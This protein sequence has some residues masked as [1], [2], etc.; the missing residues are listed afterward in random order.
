MSINDKYSETTRTDFDANFNTEYPGNQMVGYTLNGS[1]IGNTFSDASGNFTRSDYINNFWYDS[2]PLN[3][4]FASSIKLPFV[5]SSIPPSSY[6]NYM[7]YTHVDILM[8]TTLT[9]IFEIISSNNITNVT[10]ISV[11]CVGGGGHGAFDGG[12]WG[13]GGGGAGT[14][15][16]GTMSVD[17][18]IQYTIQTGKSD[19]YSRITYSDTAV[20][21][22]A[23]SGGRGM[24]QFG[25]GRSG[26]SGG[27]GSGGGDTN[28]L[29]ASPGENYPNFTAYKS[30]G[31]YGVNFK[32]GGGGGGALVNGGNAGGWEG[33]PGGAGVQWTV[34]GATYGG[35]GA[36]QGVWDY[37]NRSSGGNG[38]GGNGGQRGTDG[39]GGGGGAGQG[40]PGQRGG[41]GIVIIAVPKTSVSIPTPYQL[42]VYTTASSYST[43]TSIS[44][45]VYT[46]T[47]STEFTWDYVKSYA[48]VLVVGGGG[49]GGAS[50]GYEGGGGGGGGAVSIGYIE[51]IKDTT[52]SITVGEGNTNNS[53]QGNSSSISY[54]DG[55]TIIQSE[56][57]GRG[58]KH[59]V[60]DGNN[61]GSGGGSGGNP[62][63]YGHN[64]GSAGTDTY[65][66][67]SMYRCDGNRGHGSSYGGG[68]GGGAGVTQVGFTYSNG[69]WN[70]GKGGNGKE[71]YIDGNLYGGG[72]G[73][74]GGNSGSSVGYGDFGG[75]GGGGHGSRTGSSG[76][77][78]T[79]GGGGGGMTGY[80]PDGYKGG[81]GIVIIALIR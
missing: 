22:N 9:H 27:G 23:L 81:G 24:D 4:L 56:G 33:G 36:G 73:G 48:H 26:G 46:N 40:S 13:S 50:N 8:N 29:P 1:D 32:G 38:G 80:T 42:L 62:G 43:T 51:L 2:I 7:L 61:G 28:P 69:G 68:G 44:N 39:T 30:S 21:V 71:W 18:G 14:V 10:G 53:L 75:S 76:T 3:S 37:A 17:C 35:G 45:S 52:Y 79:G 11:L 15:Q 6:G 60:Y 54:K 25:T 74:G 12:D 59:S 41:S 57:G 77:D 16:I 31:G 55:S 47:N 5:I 72:G 58:S 34:N 78:G 70:G 67:F 19:E 66:N 20:I 49:G 65:P 64:N 63:A